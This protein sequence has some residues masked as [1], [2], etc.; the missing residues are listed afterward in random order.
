MKSGEV[1][2]KDIARELNIS[3]STVSRALKDHPD[4]SA[5]T[6]KTVNEL[7]KRLDY[8]PNTIALSLRK[9]HTNTLGVIIPQ[10]VHFFFSTIINGIEEVANENGYNILLCQS[11]ESFKK[12][13]ADCRALINSR[14]DG[15]LISCS[16]ETTNFD[17]L[18]EISNRGIPLVFYDRIYEGIHT[19]RI[20]FDDY[21]GAKA[22][23]KHLVDEGYK[24]IAHLAGPK[25]LSLSSNR[26][27]GYRD[28]LE[29]NN[30][31]FEPGLVKYDLDRLDFDGGYLKTKELLSMDSPPDA[32]F[33]H[34]DLN[35]IGAMRAVK[36]KGHR[37]PEDFGIVG[38]SNWQMS[39]YTDPPLTTVSQQGYEM[40]KEAVTMLINHIQHKQSNSIEPYMPQTRTLKTELIIRGTSKRTSITL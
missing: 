40:G 26:L 14:V 1:T 38:F 31:V 12:E 34:Q 2:L 9:S 4:I 6:K 15:M 32:I 11:N 5:K 22:A 39:S 35:A 3:P 10:V 13:L 25:D 21:Q 28:V 33:A 17:H 20:L 36:E 30:I 7:A 37:I 29:A 19:D 24:R 16:I 18:E 27:R 8:H 23:V